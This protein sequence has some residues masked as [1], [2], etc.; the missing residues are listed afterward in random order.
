MLGVWG[1]WGH[2]DAC[3]ASHARYFVR[4]CTLRNHVEIKML[5]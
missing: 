5:S 2:P 4:R 1:G 3:P